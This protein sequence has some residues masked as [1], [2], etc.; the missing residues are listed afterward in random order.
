MRE[1]IREVENPSV[2]GTIFKSFGFGNTV[3]NSGGKH[4]KKVIKS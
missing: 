4:K 2:I 3:K 1:E